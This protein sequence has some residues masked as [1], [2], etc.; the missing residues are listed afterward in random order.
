[1]VWHC[2]MALRDGEWSFTMIRENLFTF[3]S[4]ELSCWNIGLSESAVK[5]L[6]MRD[7][8]KQYGGDRVGK[9]F[10]VV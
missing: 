6:P 8:I 5:I 10:S 3:I 9:R 7:G 1:M 4:T 2:V